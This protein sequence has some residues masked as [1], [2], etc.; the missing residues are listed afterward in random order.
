MIAKAALGRKPNKVTAL[1]A[2]I[3]KAVVTFAPRLVIKLFA[4]EVKN[5]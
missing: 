2:L 3:Q 1:T 4:I 5:G